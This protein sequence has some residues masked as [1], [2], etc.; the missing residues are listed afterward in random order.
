MTWFHTTTKERADRILSEGLKVNQP[1]TYSTGSLDYMKDVY[2]MIPIF[3][4]K[5]NI[6]YDGDTSSVILE[7]NIEGL[8]DKL[9]ADIPTLAASFE[10]YIDEKGIWFEDDWFGDAAEKVH[11]AFGEDEYEISYNDLL[12]G[13]AKEPAIELTQTAAFLGNIPAFRIRPVTEQTKTARLT[14]ASSGKITVYHGGSKLRGDSF[15]LDN[16][17]SGEG[18]GILGPGVYFTDNE[19]LAKAYLKYAR[20]PAYLYTAELDMTDFYN[21]TT[22]LPERFR[23]PVSSLIKNII[24]DGSARVNS[25]GNIAGV[26]LFDHGKYPIGELVKTFGRSAGREKLLSIG[27]KGLYDVLPGGQLELCAFDMSTINVIKEEQVDF[28]PTGRY[29]SSTTLSSYG[30][31]GLLLEK[32]ML[33][34]LV[35]VANKLD[36]IGLTKEADFIDMQIL[37]LASELEEEIIPDDLSDEDLIEPTEPMY[38]NPGKTSPEE[39][40]LTMLFANE[41][42]TDMFPGQSPEEI[43]E[44]L[45]ISD[46]DEVMSVLR[47]LVDENGLYHA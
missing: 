16:I 7:V 34:D 15:S 20:G 46:D 18:I 8:E 6:H 25:F 10:A 40:L 17:G 35:K 23:G 41:T 44:A 19:R 28:D 21:P 36:S 1:A 31:S 12:Y 39:R 9:A 30:S 37:A 32:E 33:K 11:E 2:G 47:N 14:K 3:L 22:G 42:V 27:I 4:S 38:N 24:E 43:G 26:S 5:R 13:W 45:G 29:D